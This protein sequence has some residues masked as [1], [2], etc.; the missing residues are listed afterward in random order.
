MLI[1]L[2]IKGHHNVIFPRDYQNVQISLRSKL[3]MSLR[4]VQLTHNATVA[5]GGNTVPGQV[6]V[7]CC[8]RH[9][10]AATIPMQPC[11]TTASNFWEILTH[12][13][14]LHVVWS[15]LLLPGMKSKSFFN[16]L[17]KALTSVIPV[18][19]RNQYFAF[20]VS[21]FQQRKAKNNYLLKIESFTSYYIYQKST[22]SCVTYLYTHSS[23]TT[24]L[25]TS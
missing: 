15:R 25:N 21:K 19:M 6:C 13:R 18:F 12:E 1:L 4:L 5:P 23:K 16:D 22:K 17:V 20:L 2:L 7:P 14:N 10:A 9:C 8:A 24:I 11:H 3:S